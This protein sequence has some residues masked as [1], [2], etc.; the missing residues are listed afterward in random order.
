MQYPHVDQHNVV[1]ADSSNSSNSFP[2]SHAAPLEYSSGTPVDLAHA[3]FSNQGEPSHVDVDATIRRDTVELGTSARRAYEI[4]SAQW[5]TVD[6][7]ELNRLLAEGENVLVPPDVS[8]S[9]LPVPPASGYSYFPAMADDDPTGWHRLVPTAEPPPVPAPVFSEKSIPFPATSFPPRPAPP[10]PNV[11]PQEPAFE[12]TFDRVQHPS[13]FEYSPKTSGY[14][15]PSVGH[16]HIVPIKSRPNSHLNKQLVPIDPEYSEGNGD[17]R[18]VTLRIDSTAM[19]NVIDDYGLKGGHESVVYDAVF[20]S[21]N[22]TLITC[23]SDGKV[24]IWDMIERQVEQE[25]IPHEGE[26]VTMVYPLPDEEEDQSSM[27]LL[28]LSASRSLRIWTVSET[29]AVMLR[30]SKVQE[31][32]GDL[33]MNVPRISKE[34]KQRAISAATSAAIKASEPLSG[35][36][37]A[38]NVG[39]AE[40]YRDFA[41]V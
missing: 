29:H 33:Y 6:Q 7:D 14:H 35:T 18:P 19:V 11:V 30:D 39:D 21:G 13:P 4:A 12:R 34:L 23:G 9:D 15:S 20:L 1:S 22:K 2:S 31:S 5:T 3:T 10:M 26:P 17:S 8:G 38:E 24:C 25:F 36:M 41:G 40:E 28:T 16:F 32:E 27:T 37:P